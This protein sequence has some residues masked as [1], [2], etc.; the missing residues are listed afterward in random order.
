M[1]T[2]CTTYTHETYVIYI[3]I[4]IR[5]HMNVCGGE[6][7]LRRNFVVLKTKRLLLNMEKARWRRLEGSTCRDSVDVQMGNAGSPFTK[8]PLLMNS[9]SSR[10]WILWI[11]TFSGLTVDGHNHAPHL[12]PW[13]TIV[14]WYLQGSQHLMI[15][16]VVPKRISQP[17]NESQVSLWP[18]RGQERAKMA[19]VLRPERISAMDSPL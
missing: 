17:S 12:K 2:H 10:R 11:L 18:L 9:K 13:E 5:M 7:A 8:P 19:G 3:Y 15:S 16:Q 6:D 4:Q 14:C 1:R